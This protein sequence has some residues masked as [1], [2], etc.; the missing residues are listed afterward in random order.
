MK[1]YRFYG[2][3]NAI[4]FLRPGAK[5]EIYIAAENTRFTKWDDPRPCPSLDEIYKVL[6]KIK[7][8]EDSIDT[9]WTDEQIET[10][11]IFGTVADLRALDGFHYLKH[12]T[13]DQMKES[14]EETKK[15]LELN[16]E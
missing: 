15:K 12:V 8:F 16:N 11:N 13:P 3:E 7:N 2:V 4:D 6:E 1:I 14:V 9:I 10:I 5:F